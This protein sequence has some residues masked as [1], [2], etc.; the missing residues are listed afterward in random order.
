MVFYF[1]M[2][3]WFISGI[4]FLV[5]FIRWFINKRNGKVVV[6]SLLISFISL[7]I[8]IVI[9]ANEP[10]VTN[11]FVMNGRE[12]S[13]NQKS[14]SNEEL[15]IDALQF[16]KLTEAELKNLLGE[17]ESK[18]DWKF[19]SLNGNSYSATTWIYDNGNQEFMFID[20]KVVR[21]TFYGTGQKYKNGEHALSL[22]GIKPGPNLTVVADTGT[23]IRYQ[24]VHESMKIDEFWITGDI[25]KTIDSVKITY[26]LRY[27]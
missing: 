1:F 24:R 21:F 8:G 16:A 25:D 18:E 17:P 26:D 12:A 2:F 27:F 14:T 19:D 23:A 15:I 22:F 10:V 4:I 6:A 9:T 11:N 5:T 13:S 20:G 3:L 7:I